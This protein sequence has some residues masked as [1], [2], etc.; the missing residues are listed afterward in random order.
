MCIRDRVISISDRIVVMR[1]GE[2]VSTLDK[3]DTNP[4]E[5]AELMVGRG[6]DAS[7]MA[8]PRDFS[9]AKTVL[10]IRNLT[11]LMPGELVKGI[12][13]DVKE[14]EILGI[15]GLAGHGKI[16]VA[17]G[18]MGL[19]E[20]S[21]EVTY[22][23]KPLNIHSTYDV[24]KKRINF[25]S[26]DRK[27]VGLI[28]GNSIEQ[29]II[30]PALR[31][32]KKYLKHYGL[33]TQ[34]DRKAMREQAE[35]MIE[36]LRIKCTSPKQRVGA[37]S[38]G[39]QQKVCIAEALTLEPEFLFISEPTRGIDIGA[40]TLILDYLKKLN[41]EQGMTIVVTSSELKELRSICDRIVIIANGK[42]MGVL[43]PNASDAEY[44]LMMS[45]IQ[46]AQ[47]A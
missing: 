33:F 31:V 25:V 43:A 39:N 3:K 35:R 12:D 21:G 27:N 42:I 5:L 8:K 38:G 6:I 36:E 9:G 40:K 47:K 7:A 37:L 23:G 20:S 45:G 28:L 2:L 41:R 26:E 17:N 1:D 19:Y 30:T 11:V 13:L 46:P 18:I 34:L 44:G 16:G 29:N 14:G 10:S 15:A 24:M 4:V 22:K 32:H